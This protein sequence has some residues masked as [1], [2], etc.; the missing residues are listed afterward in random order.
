MTGLVLTPHT[1]CA[2]ILVL[3]KQLLP[4]QPDGLDKDQSYVHRVTLFIQKYFGSQY[5]EATQK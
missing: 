3:D 4:H 1:L 5:H 2:K